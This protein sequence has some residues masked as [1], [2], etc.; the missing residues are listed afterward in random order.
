MELCP[1][2]EA[3]SRLA[4]QEFPKILWN[5]KVYYRVHRSPPLV[6]LRN[7]NNPLHNIPYYFSKI[8]FNIIHPLTPSGFPTKILH[9]FLF[10]QISILKLK[11]R[12]LHHNFRKT[13]VCILAN[14]VTDCLSLYFTMMSVSGLHLWCHGRKI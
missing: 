8:Y 2:W 3:A 9:T 13:S 7:K 4:T 1:S 10:K 11:C 14:L 5:P 6:P 12:N